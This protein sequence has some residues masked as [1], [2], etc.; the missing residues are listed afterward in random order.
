MTKAFST[1]YYYSIEGEGF[2][3]LSQVLVDALVNPLF[4]LKNIQKEINNVNSEISMRMTSNKQMG[5]YKLLKR[6]GNLNAKIYSDGFENIDPEG[7]DVVDLQAQLQAFHKKYY[8]ANIMTLAVISDEE[9]F[10]IKKII[11]ENYSKIPNKKVQRDL[12]KND[13]SPLDQDTIGN[14]YYLQGFEE[15]SQISLVFPLKS[16]KGQ[17]FSPIDFFST[18]FNFDFPESLKQVL[19]EQDLLVDL[20]D[21]LLMQDYS[22]NIYK[23]T[24]QVTER[25]R[26][27]ISDIISAFFQLVSQ[28]RN[29]S[30]KHLFFT[31]LAKITKYNF[32]FNNL[33][34][35]ISI[36]SLESNPFERVLQISES[37]Q[38]ND[39]EDVMAAG[40]I[41][42]QY[43]EQQF[44]DLLS[45][46]NPNNMMLVYEGK[47]FLLPRKVEKDVHRRK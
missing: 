35:S 37:L 41:M 26:T 21:E 46:L 13:F 24:F 43:D 10:K 15:D 28:V 20:G 2:E 31:Q 18:I 19:I 12:L 33:T 11:Q 23:V 36:S 16:Y 38:E 7:V 27:Q 25:G 5:V 22:S 14:I 40:K 3:E 30:N 4:D 42:A 34:S 39:A 32:L 45:Q 44:H 9:P 47:D 17:I 29:Q 8:S 1:S 6:V